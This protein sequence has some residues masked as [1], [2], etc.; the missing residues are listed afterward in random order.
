MGQTKFQIGT[1]EKKQLPFFTGLMEAS[2]AARAATDEPLLLVGISKED[3]A[4]GALAAH[5][6][7]GT[8]LS[9]DSFFIHPSV[10]RQ[11]AGT[12]LL[13]T[14]LDQLFDAHPELTVSFDFLEETE[15]TEALCEFLIAKGLAEGAG[16]GAVF[17]FPLI[18]FPMRETVASLPAPYEAVPFASLRA[19]ALTD[20]FSAGIRRGVFLSTDAHLVNTADP[21]CSLLVQKGETPVCFLAAEPLAKGNIALQG[22]SFPEDPAF[23]FLP[24]LMN[25]IDLLRGA[26]DEETTLLIHTPGAAEAD[27]LRELVPEAVN[28][29]HHFDIVA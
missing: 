19:A 17:R 8:K 24:L 12:L 10:R 4:C 13:D 22:F 27:L 1:I 2:V 14:F 28:I 6:T 23:P 25:V 18:R 11:G 26:Y 7:S 29:A 20:F 9:V 16:D 15:D 5:L 21:A 3:R